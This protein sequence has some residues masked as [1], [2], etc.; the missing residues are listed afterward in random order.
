M[1]IFFFVNCLISNQSNDKE[2]FIFNPTQKNPGNAS[3]LDGVIIFIG[4]RSC[5]APSVEKQLFVTTDRKLVV[6]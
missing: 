3:N 4:V 2:S 5:D 1:R 6:N